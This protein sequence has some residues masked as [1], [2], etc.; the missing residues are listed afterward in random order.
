MTQQSLIPKGRPL[1]NDQP[2]TPAQR[3]AK[4]RAHRAANG[5]KQVWLC[6]AEQKIIEVFRSDPTLLDHALETLIE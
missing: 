1:I 6:P 3:M 2:M 4:M 5:Y